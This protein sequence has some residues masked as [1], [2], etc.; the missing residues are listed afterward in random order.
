MNQRTRRVQ[1]VGMVVL[2]AL[3]LMFGNA[4]AALANPIAPSGE[5]SEGLLLAQAAGDVSVFERPSFINTCRSSGSTELVVY[6]N[7]AQTQVVG[8]IPAFTRITLTG[9]VGSGVVQVRTPLV[10][11]VRSATLLTNCDARPP[12][13]DLCFQVTADELVVRDA[14]YGNVLTSV[15]RG[16]RVFSSNPPQRQTTSDGRI[17]IRVTVRGVTGWIAESGTGGVGRNITPCP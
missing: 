1:K 13:A 11:W 16:D 4:P 3:L 6:A 12:A 8:R 2:T 7:T 14:P 10:G 5:Q 17:W 9:I 15:V